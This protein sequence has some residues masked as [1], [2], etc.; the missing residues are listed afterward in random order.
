[1][2][3][4][5]CSTTMLK[6]HLECCPSSQFS[7]HLSNNV[8][9]CHL[10]TPIYAGSANFFLPIIKIGSGVSEPQVAENR[11]LPLT[12]GIALTTVYALTCYTVMCFSSLVTFSYYSYDHNVPLNMLSAKAV[13]CW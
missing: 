6:K 10:K 3:E 12:G 5:D 11:Y 7:E 8:L 13:A 1:M 2:S 9:S 4:Y